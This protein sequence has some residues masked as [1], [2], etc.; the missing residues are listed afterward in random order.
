MA[1]EFPELTSFGTL[2][3]FACALEEAAGRMAGSLAALDACA[4]WREVLLDCAA[5]HA[6]RG[7]DLE[8]LRR[9]RLNE[10]VLQAI[11]GMD[12]ADYV[13]T[14][15]VPADAAAPHCLEALASVE[16]SAARLHEDG[17]RVAAGVMPGLDRP[18]Q[19]LARESRDLAASLRA[20]AAQ[21][22]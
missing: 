14:A 8:R 22:G 17:A 6:K 5:R 19:R 21:G 7:R 2:F 4:A 15:D 16:E 13:P 11:S 12:R 1:S 20:R 3:R 10:V 9:E 18:L